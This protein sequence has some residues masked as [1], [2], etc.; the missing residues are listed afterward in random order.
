MFAVSAE[1]TFVVSLLVMVALL[2][3]ATVIADNL[4]EGRWNTR[5]AELSSYEHERFRH[6]MRWVVALR[7]GGVTSFLIM[8][9]AL[10][11]ISSQ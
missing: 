1:A 7:I 4:K 8:L 9:G 6:L 2:S 3:S 5:N 11:A 10:T